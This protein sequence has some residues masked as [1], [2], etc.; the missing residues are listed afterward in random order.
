MARKKR[1][2]ILGD[3]HFPYTHLQTIYHF[4]DFCKEFEPDYIVQMGDLYDCYAQSRF[5]KKMTDPE[6]EIKEAKKYGDWFWGEAK[7]LNVKCIQLLGNHD[8][9]PLHRAVEKCPEILPFLKWENAFKFKGVK[10]VYDTRAEFVLDGVNWTHGH[11]QHGTHMLENMMPTICGHTH[12]GGVVFK[13]FRNNLIWELNVG[14]AGDPTSEALA[15]TPKQYVN[16]THGF[17]ALDEHG[18]RFIPWDKKKR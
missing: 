11:R 16:W 18:P 5:A 17:G 15:Y 6:W 12:T 7:K 13:T 2:A 4:L 8:N 10:T 9:R 3:T 1:F 14:Y